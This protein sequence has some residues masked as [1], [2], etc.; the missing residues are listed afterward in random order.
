MCTPI[1]MKLG[2][3]IPSIALIGDGIFF[4]FL[5]TA[6]CGVKNC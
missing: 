2:M 5:S 3:S 4:W 1:L 6:Y